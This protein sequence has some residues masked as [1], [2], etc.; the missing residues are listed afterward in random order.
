MIITIDGPAGSGKSTT[1]KL[2]AKELGGILLD[3]GA[4]YRSVTH[5]A[6][7]EK[8]DTKDGK[9]MAEIA[10]NINIE[11]VE[12]EGP[13]RTLVNGRDCSADIRKKSVDA[14]VS[15]V[16]AHKDVRAEMVTLQRKIA[17]TSNTVVCEGRDIGSVVFPDA[18]FKF[19]IHADTVKRA[20]RRALERGEEMDDA[21][22]EEIKMRDHLDSTRKES[23]MII[24]DGAHVIDNTDLSIDE[25]LKKLLELCA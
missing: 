20:A 8:A 12:N 22:L 13:Q 11:F 10:R 1:A 18:D 2:L 9:R 24:P 16:A 6:L 14:N 23:P 7:E 21:K 5:I 15:I 3:T 25:T 17:T 4:M 19:Y